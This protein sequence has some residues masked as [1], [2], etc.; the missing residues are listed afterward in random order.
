M[1][2]THQTICTANFNGSLQSLRQMFQQTL[3]FRIQRI[4][5]FGVHFI[6]TRV[7]ARRTEIASWWRKTGTR[8]H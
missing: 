3:E 2:V 6:G 5:T 8:F 1:I 4:Q 7:R